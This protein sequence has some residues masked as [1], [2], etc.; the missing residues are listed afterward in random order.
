M[1]DAAVY[2]N[3]KKTL[4]KNISRICLFIVEFM[5]HFGIFHSDVYMLNKQCTIQATAEHPNHHHASMSQFANSKT[6]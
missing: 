5:R 1:S 4:R 6:L 3:G 2:N